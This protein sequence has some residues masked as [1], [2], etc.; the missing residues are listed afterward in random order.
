M[1]GWGFLGFDESGDG[2]EFYSC[3]RYCF[4]QGFPRDY[5]WKSVLPLG[6]VV[7]VAQHRIFGFPVPST[8]TYH[9]LA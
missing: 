5:F 6:K 3:S 2:K 9:S 4:C 7:M 1:L 8:Q